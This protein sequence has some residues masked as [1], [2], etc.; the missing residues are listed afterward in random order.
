VAGAVVG[1]VA[2]GCAAGAGG[3]AGTGGAAGCAHNID[4]SA[5]DAIPARSFEFPII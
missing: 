4:E 5:R 2:G 1:A 3:C